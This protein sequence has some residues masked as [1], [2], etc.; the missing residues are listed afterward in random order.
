MKM[1]QIG[2]TP[3]ASTR[4]VFMPGTGGMAYIFYARNFFICFFRE[5]RPLFRMVK[6]GKS[7]KQIIAHYSPSVARKSQRLEY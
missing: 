7:E 5:L 1:N 4:R 3:P 2:G 6:R